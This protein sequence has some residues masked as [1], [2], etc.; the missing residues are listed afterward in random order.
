MILLKRMGLRYPKISNYPQYNIKVMKMSGLSI[1]LVIFSHD[2][3]SWSVIREA[4]IA[5][6]VIIK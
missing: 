3:K 1:G 2:N 5:L 4:H 6:N